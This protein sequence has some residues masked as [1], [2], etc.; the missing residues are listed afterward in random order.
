MDI[1]KYEVLLAV[2]DKG[3]FFKAAND[4]GYTQSGITYMMNSLEKE[5]GV[6]LL[7][8]S[9][10]GVMLT[11]EGERFLPEIRQ[12]VQ[13]NKRLEQD[14]SEAKGNLVGKVRVGCF[15]TIVCALMPR[16]MRLMREKYPQLQIDIVEENSV[17]VLTDWL[18]SGFIDVA[19]TSRQP[20]YEYDWFPLLE[21]RY[22]VVMPKTSPLTALDV[23]PAKKIEDQALFIYRGSDGID[24]DVAQYLKRNQVHL[25]PNFTT[26]SDYTVLY[27]IEEKLGI[28]MIPELL[29]R[30]L[31]QRFPTLTTRLLDP[32]AQR[33]IGM[34]VLKYDDAVPSVKCFVRTVR[35]S[36][37]AGTLEG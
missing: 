29:T 34:A 11:L 31:E 21:D 28:G 18:R 32:P 27:M 9:N 4:L 17:G 36:M 25:V 22:V 7:Q 20:R 6:P 8:R 35:D 2:V 23:I 5:C 14:F 12:L 16:M 30:N 33:E 1:K 24:A 19:V 37:T 15:P 10:K 26:S 13:L 3:S